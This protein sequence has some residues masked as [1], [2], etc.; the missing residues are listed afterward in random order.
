MSDQMN[1]VDIN[2]TLHRRSA[3]ETHGQCIAPLGDPNARHR[4]RCQVSR[5][6][7]ASVKT[8]ARQHV[9]LKSAL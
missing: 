4:E 7:P 1:A 2:A 9:T 6:D 5:I 3:F 8:A